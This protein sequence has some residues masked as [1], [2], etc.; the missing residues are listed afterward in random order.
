MSTSAA[1]AVEPHVH[2][3]TGQWV[4]ACSV[5]DI[6]APA[7]RTLDVLL[8]LLWRA[9]N[10]DDRPVIT[11]SHQRGDYRLADTMEPAQRF[12]IADPAGGA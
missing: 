11:L 12:F 2:A 9:R 10:V 5:G 8:S 1:I 6:P 4:A 3:A 7:G